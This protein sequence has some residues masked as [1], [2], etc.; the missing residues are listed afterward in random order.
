MELPALP[1]PLPMPVVDSHCHLDSTQAHL[2]LS[3][4]K[5]SGWPPM[6]ASPESCRSAATPMAAAGR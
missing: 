1:D 6:L 2:A 4:T 5:P 3:P